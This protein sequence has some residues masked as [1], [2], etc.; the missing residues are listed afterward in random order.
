M[1]I[2]ILARG[3][4]R[5]AIAVIFFF[6]FTILDDFLRKRNTASVLKDQLGTKSASES[7]LSAVTIFILAQVQ[8]RPAIPAI[9]FFFFFDIGRLPDRLWSDL[10]ELPFFR[11]TLTSSVYSTKGKKNPADWLP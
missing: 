2:F 9:F 10:V 11:G 3:K 5:S 8:P 7:K 6:Y 1:T 4:P